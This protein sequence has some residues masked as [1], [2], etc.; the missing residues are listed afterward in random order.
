M[1]D[2]VSVGIISARYNLTC[3]WSVLKNVPVSVQEN[4]LDIFEKAL[5][6]TFVWITYHTNICACAYTKG[7]SRGAHN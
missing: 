6:I 7:I 5:Q 1:S 3:L 2:L 4:K